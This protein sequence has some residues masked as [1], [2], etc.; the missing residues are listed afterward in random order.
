MFRSTIAN[1]GIALLIALLMAPF[2]YMLITGDFPGA[3]LTYG[4]EEDAPV[5][6]GLITFHHN[7]IR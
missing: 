3:A 6:D 7:V 5:V 4:I 1:V 2:A